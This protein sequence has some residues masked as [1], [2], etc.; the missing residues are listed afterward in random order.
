MMRKNLLS[1]FRTPP[2]IDKSLGYSNPRFFVGAHPELVEE[3]IASLLKIVGEC[4]SRNA[5]RILNLIILAVLGFVGA[6]VAI[7][8]YDV[9]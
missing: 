3:L 8:R 5:F 4:L 9:R 6:Y 2:N 7:L 1:V